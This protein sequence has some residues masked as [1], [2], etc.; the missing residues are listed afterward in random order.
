MRIGGAA[1]EIDHNPEQR[2]DRWLPAALFF[3]EA[4]RGDVDGSHECAVRVVETCH[5]RRR[6]NSRSNRRQQDVTAVVERGDPKIPAARD[7]LERRIGE[8]HIPARIPAGIFVAR[9]EQ[10]T[11]TAVERID[12]GL[13]RARYWQ[14]LDAA[15]DNDSTVAEIAITALSQAEINGHSLPP[16]VPRSRAVLNRRTAT[17][18]EAAVLIN[19]EPPQSRR[20]Q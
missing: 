17:S 6:L 5:G 1:K 15:M 19:M 3:Q 20:L 4:L 14:L 11:A 10:H 8:S 7:N 9:S 12:D 18:S 13:D 16:F 2:K